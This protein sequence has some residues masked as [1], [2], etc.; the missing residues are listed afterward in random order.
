MDENTKI[1]E[2]LFFTEITENE[3]R[4]VNLMRTYIAPY[5]DPTSFFD[6]LV[7]K[8]AHELLK[9]AIRLQAFAEV[10][11]YE[12][13]SDKSNLE[14]LARIDMFEDYLASKSEVVD[15]LMTSIMADMVQNTEGDIKP[16]TVYSKQE[17]VAEEEKLLDKINQM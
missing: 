13:Q 11:G 2:N 7:E 4:V 5:Q 17:A 6:D 15:R 10:L 8:V 9:K 12:R 1:E 3:K 16:I 14:I